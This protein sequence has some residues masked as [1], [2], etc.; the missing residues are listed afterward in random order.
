MVILLLNDQADVS[1]SCDNDFAEC[2]KHIR[3]AN[4]MYSQQ[5]TKLSKCVI[6][7]YVG[8]NVYKMIPVC[9]RTSHSKLNAKLFL[10]V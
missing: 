4:I 1:G 10:L 5:E 7:T 6:I 3:N 2:Q 8:I 9:C